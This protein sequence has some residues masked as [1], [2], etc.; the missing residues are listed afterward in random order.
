MQRITTFLTFNDQA[1]E[2][3]NFYT[4]VFP[5]S[6]VVSANHVRSGGPGEQDTLFS[7]T[8]ELDGQELMLLNGGPAFTFAQGISLFVRCEMQT[9]VD[10]FWTKLSDGGEE[11][12]CGWLTDRFGVSWQIVPRVLSHLLSDE[13]TKRTDRVLD[14]MILMKKLDIEALQNAYAG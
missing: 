9:E 1:E 14:A 13:D 8:I 6:R 4:S 2:A 11:G 5:N 3:M 12:S 10:E 7:A